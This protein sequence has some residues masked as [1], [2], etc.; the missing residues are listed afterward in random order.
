LR[1]FNGRPVLRVVHQGR[2]GLGSVGLLLAVLMSMEQGG[3]WWIRRQ[4]RLAVCVDDLRQQHEQ[5]ER[6][7]NQPGADR[8]GKVFT[9]FRIVPISIGRSVCYRVRCAIHEGPF[10]FLT[11]LL[12]AILE[13][14]ARP[15]S[16]RPPRGRLNETWTE[17]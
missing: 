2:E 7:E 16:G 4:A 6:R 8:S 15:A 11:S 14:E 3:G 10:L 13:P 17:R 12:G 1:P 5:T 9:V